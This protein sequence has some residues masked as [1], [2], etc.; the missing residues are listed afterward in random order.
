M[1]KRLALVIGSSLYRDETLSRLVSPDADVGALAD[2]L[3]DP[4][5]GGFDDVKLLV[6]MVSYT[7]RK[8]ISEFFSRKTWNLM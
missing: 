7:V 2:T 5:M 6:N 8:E 3:L 4:E 1:S